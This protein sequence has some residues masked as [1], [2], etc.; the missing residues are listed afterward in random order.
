MFS[1]GHS[2]QFFLNNWAYNFIKIP[3]ETAHQGDGGVRAEHKLGGLAPV[4]GHEDAEVGLKASR[5]HHLLPHR[6][7]RLQCEQKYRPLLEHGLREGRYQ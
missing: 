4:A 1:T 3:G 2:S 7:H 5:G 6:L